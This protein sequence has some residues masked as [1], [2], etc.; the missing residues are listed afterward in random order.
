MRANFLKVRLQSAPLS[1]IP[2]PERKGRPLLAWALA[3]A[4]FVLL[5]ASCSI[6]FP[7]VSSP[8]ITAVPTK[9][10]IPTKVAQAMPTLHPTRSIDS[11]ISTLTPLPTPTSSTAPIFEQYTEVYANYGWQDTGIFVFSG[12]QVQIQYISGEWTHWIGQVPYSDASGKYGYICATYM[13]PSECVEPIPDFPTGALIGKIGGQLLKIGNTISFTSDDDGYLLLRINDADI[14]LYD[15][16]GTIT[17]R[18]TVHRS[19]AGNKTIPT[20]TPIPALPV[21]QESTVV[22]VY[23]I[24]FDPE[25]NGRPLTQHKGFN[26]PHLLMQQYIKDIETVTGGSVTYRVIQESVVRKFP[27]KTDGF[28]YTP[29]EYWR[30]IN[31][32]AGNAP[33]YC[34]RSVDYSAVVNTHY[35]GR[36]ICERVQNDD[37]DEVWELEGGWLGFR[38][39]YII[40]PNT[41]CPGLAKEF[42]LM[43]FNY[44]RGVAEMLHSMGH[45]VEEVLQ[46]KLGIVL[47]DRFDGQRHR[48]AQDYEYSPV[49]D[50]RHPEVNAT[51]T[52][53]GNIHFPPNAYLHYQYDRD[54]PV[55]SDC[56]DWQFFPNLR[57]EKRTINCSTWGCDHYGFMKWWLSHIPHNPGASGGVYHN[58]WKYI[59]QFDR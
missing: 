52:H 22:N 40:K 5:T 41:L 50:D 8:P 2:E 14:G 57:G 3:S 51:E 25:I 28:V 55:L 21:V 11:P 38:E 20:P 15:N 58:W 30:C 43:T 9:T 48:Y 7:Q 42:T 13:Q 23:V 24:I 56:D 35:D 45:R 6:S 26:D 31:S 37:I 27:T 32:T 1:Q 44:S 46:E 33:E 18:V 36:S 53:C 47:W 29:E 17:V 49:P 4:I 16:A 59:F 19:L 54:F 10:A 34:H 39:Y 12:D